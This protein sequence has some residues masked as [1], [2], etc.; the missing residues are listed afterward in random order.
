MMEESNKMIIDSVTRL[1]QAVTDLKTLVVRRTPPCGS[2]MIITL[3]QISASKEDELA[4]NEEFL[5]AKEILEVA[6]A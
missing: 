4:E 3:S 2:R 5:K 6:S 1:Q